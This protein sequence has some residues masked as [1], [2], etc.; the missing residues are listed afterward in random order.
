[1]NNI[2]ILNFSKKRLNSIYKNFFSFFSIFSIQTIIQIL[3]PPAMIFTWG[4]EKFGIWILIINI[5]SILT[6]VE[7]VIFTANR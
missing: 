5:P 1:M 2:N 7:T 6:P 4:A 3:F